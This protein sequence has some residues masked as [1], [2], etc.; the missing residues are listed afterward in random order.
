MNQQGIWRD[1]EARVAAGVTIPNWTAANGYIGD[2]FSVVGL[3]TGY[4]DIEA[5]GAEYIQH[6]PR[7]DFERLWAVWDEYKSGRL[8]RHELRDMSRF[9]KYIIS[10]LHWLE[11]EE[12]WRPDQH[13]AVPTIGLHH[14]VR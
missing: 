10:L 3:R 9:S 7:T 4:L 13:V 11:Q 8:L 14:S 5:P 12:S 2:P 6:I 1:L